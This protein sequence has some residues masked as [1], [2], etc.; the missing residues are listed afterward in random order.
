M[1]L[2]EGATIL[3]VESKVRSHNIDPSNY[4]YKDLCMYPLMEAGGSEDVRLEYSCVLSSHY[5]T[6]NNE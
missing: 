1:G 3:Q 2:C 4:Q 6:G 5:S